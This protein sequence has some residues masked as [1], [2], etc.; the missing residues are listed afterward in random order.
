MEPCSFPV[1]F[2]DQTPW[3]YLDHHL[4]VDQDTLMYIDIWHNTA[5]WHKISLLKFPSWLNQWPLFLINIFTDCSS[6]R[7][8]DVEEYKSAGNLIPNMYFGEIL[9]D[10]NPVS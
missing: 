3:F 6:A 9:C 8:S 7:E 10:Q 4:W 2:L 1:V 5:M